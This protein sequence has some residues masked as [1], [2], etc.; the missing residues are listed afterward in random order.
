MKKPKI[1]IIMPSLNVVNYIEKC[2]DSVIRQSL[3]EIEIICVD[4]Q[5]NDGT[6]EVLREYEKKDKRVHVIVSDKK[7]YGY[8]MNLGI[9]ASSGE[10]IGIVET[11]DWVNPDMFKILYEAAEKEKVEMVKSNFYLYTTQKTEE[12]KFFENL[13]CCNYNEK[14]V[15]MNCKEL[16]A[17]APAIWSGIYKKSMIE[18]NKIFF[19]E[20]LGA[21]YQDTSFHFMVC[22]VASSCY[23]LKDAFLHYRTD[24]D[25]SS[26]NSPG[27][28]YCISDEMHYYEKFLDELPA[29]RGKIEEYYMTLKYEKYRW[30]CERLA[31]QFKE[32]FVELMYSEFTNANEKGLLNESI[33]RKADWLNLQIL[34]ENPRMYLL[35][36]RFLNKLPKNSNTEK[37]KRIL[38]KIFQNKTRKR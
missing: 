23:L 35:E 32:Q 3:I 33:F 1:S 9:A 17:T 37:F 16:F 7:S 5:S 30:N 22:S 6:L 21:S 19:N 28:V 27:K 34:L 29:V 31:P 10:Y 24:N 25:S 26:V 18:K 12:N 15:P 8:Q 14:F 38:R 36:E 13:S 20:T 2:I 11:D 4:A